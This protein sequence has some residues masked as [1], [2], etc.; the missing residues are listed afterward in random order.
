[1]FAI[2]TKNIMRLERSKTSF[3]VG[4]KQAGNE[5][6]TINHKPPNIANIESES[7]QIVITQADQGWVDL[8]HRRLR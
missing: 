6:W 3:V 8:R 7:I 4:N 2:I 1:M 5:I